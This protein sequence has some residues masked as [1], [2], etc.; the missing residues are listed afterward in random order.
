MFFGFSTNLVGTLSC[1]DSPT[2]LPLFYTRSMIAQGVRVVVMRNRIR[3]GSH[4]WDFDIDL[5][6]GH[7]QPFSDRISVN[8]DAESFEVVFDICCCRLT[9]VI[10]LE[11]VLANGHPQ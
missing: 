7:F 11:S 3:F 4:L 5:I 9:P 6:G 10:E 1:L 8:A 2:N